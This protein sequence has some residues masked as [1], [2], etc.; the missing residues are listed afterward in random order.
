MKIP[1]NLYWWN[2]TQ[3][4]NLMPCTDCSH[5]AISNQFT[6]TLD[7]LTEFALLGEASSNVTATPTSTPA[8]TETTA[9]TFTRIPSQIPLGMPTETPTPTYMPSLTPTDNPTTTPTQS[10]LST[11]TATPTQAPTNT[12]TATLTQVP[13]PTAT[14][15]FTPTPTKIPESN[16]II[17]AWPEEQVISQGQMITYTVTLTSTNGFQAPVTLSING[18]PSGATPFWENNPITPSS[19]TI[20]TISTVITATPGSYPLTVSG[21]SGEKTHNQIINL[22]IVNFYK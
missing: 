7:H 19:S 6:I 11:F 2:S 9:P 18:L 10:P 22:E 16:F 3:W 21:T 8:L 12:S 4:T 5:D 15:P 14:P 17:D 13:M 20:L 1:L